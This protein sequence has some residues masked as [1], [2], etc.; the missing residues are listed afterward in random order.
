MIDGLSLRLGWCI[1]EFCQL[2]IEEYLVCSPDQLQ[3]VQTCCIIPHVLGVMEIVIAR[4]VNKRK[5]SGRRPRKFIAAV[6]LC[7]V[8]EFIGLPKDEDEDVCF[9]EGEDYGAWQLC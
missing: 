1:L 8:V 2:A 6:S 9:E 5:N 7:T 4:S 3:E